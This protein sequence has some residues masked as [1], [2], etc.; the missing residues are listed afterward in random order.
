[1]RNSFTR[2]PEKITSSVL[3]VSASAVEVNH[4]LWT[5]WW[6]LLNGSTQCKRVVVEDTAD[7]LLRC[8][9]LTQKYR[10]ADLFIYN[11][12]AKN[13][14]VLEGLRLDTGW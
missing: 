6:G 14:G 5:F 11:D 10:I 7:H 2:V 3:E 8:P 12:T 13:C 9:L 1:M 4:T